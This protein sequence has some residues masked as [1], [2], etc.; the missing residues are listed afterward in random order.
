[1][2]ENVRIEGEEA[3]AE[4]LRSKE[5][6][7]RAAQ[8]RWVVEVG[9]KVDHMAK[10]AAPVRT[11]ALRAD[12]HFDPR[13]TT[14]LDGVQGEVRSGDAIDYAVP[15]HQGTRGRAGRP[16][17]VQGAEASRRFAH[18]LARSMLGRL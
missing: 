12:I 10:R 16:Y 2:S 15:V 5:A 4:A 6:Q 7:L 1:M 3:V 13:V 11:G 18:E 17:M 14:T 9:L 8:S